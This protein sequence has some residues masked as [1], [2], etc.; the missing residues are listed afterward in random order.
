MSHN[1]STMGMS[2]WIG[3]PNPPYPHYPTQPY[4]VPSMVHLH[5]PIDTAWQFH[6]DML[7]EMKTLNNV[8]E[9]ILIHLQHVQRGG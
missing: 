4:P 5:T 9:N 6:Q 2:G 1:Q 8:L 7:A 3:D